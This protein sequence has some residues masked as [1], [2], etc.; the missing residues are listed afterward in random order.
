MHG[1][2]IC[3][4]LKEELNTKERKVRLQVKYIIITKLTTML[5]CLKAL[6]TILL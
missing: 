3:N 4:I 6:S 2:L 1:M 5:F